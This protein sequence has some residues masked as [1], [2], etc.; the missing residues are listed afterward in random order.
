VL[1]AIQAGKHVFVEKPLCLT[2]E[3][4]QQIEEALAKAGAAAPLVMVGFNRRF[5]SAA[6]QVKDLFKDISD[7]LTIS[8][9]FNAGAIPADHWTQDDAE[10]GGRIIGEAC[11]GIDLATY[12][13]GSPPVRVF[14]ESVG[15]AEASDTREVT[16]DQCFITV[17]HANGSVSN[18]AYLSGGDKAFQKERVEVFGGGRIAVIDDFRSVTTCVRGK[19][20]RYKLGS[21]DKGHQA[22]IDAFSRCVSEGGAAPISWAELRNVSLASIL[23]VRSLREGAAC[24]L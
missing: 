14:A 2:V 3:E 6:R 8:V 7:P 15:T 19:T 11:H 12:L 23:A 16:D 5:S 13:A 22:E 21:Q 20:K 4:L 10:G 9:R 18:V 1:K 24:D 17:R